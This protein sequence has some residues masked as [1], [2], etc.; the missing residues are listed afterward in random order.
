MTAPG[1]TFKEAGAL[2]VLTVVVRETVPGTYETAVDHANFGVGDALEAAKSLRTLS[3]S[4]LMTAVEH[5][6]ADRVLEYLYPGI[7]SEKA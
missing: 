3:D 6:G 4:L 2:A 5:L 7:Q 1:Q